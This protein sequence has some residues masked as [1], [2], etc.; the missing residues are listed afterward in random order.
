MRIRLTGL[1]NWRGSTAALAKG[2]PGATDFAESS[3]AI[4]GFG[5]SGKMASTGTDRSTKPAPLETGRRATRPRQHCSPNRTRRPAD[6]QH[7]TQHRTPRHNGPLAGDP[8]RVAKS[9]APLAQECA[10]RG[11][12]VSPSRQLEL[13]DSAA[14]SRSRQFRLTGL[15]NT[16]PPHAPPAPRVV[17]P[18]Q[19]CSPTRTRRPADDQHH[20]R[21]RTLCPN[22]P[23]GR[24]PETK[25]RNQPHHW[26]RSAPPG[27]RFRRVVNCT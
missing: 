9:T 1:D 22:G 21:T 3:T 14:P 25:R 20:T 8:N 16:P 23:T 27:D 17:R 12:Q 2:V 19:D 11:R 24:R 18:R 26:R 6:D 13:T 15:G 7:H 4:D 5:G 10:A